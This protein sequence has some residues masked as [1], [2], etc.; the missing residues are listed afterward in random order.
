MRIW[1]AGGFCIRDVRRLL[2]ACESREP[3]Q[4]RCP[5]LP[6]TTCRPCRP[7]PPPPSQRPQAPRPTRPPSASR[8]C[9]ALSVVH[10]HDTPSARRAG[11]ASANRARFAALQGGRALSPSRLQRH[12][13][14]CRRAE[15]RMLA[16]QLRAR[17]P[18]ARRWSAGWRAH[19][20]PALRV[21][22]LEW[23]FRQPVSLHLS[24]RASS[25]PWGDS[26]C[27]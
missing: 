8:T 23:R 2:Q 22:Q 7:R 21:C 10:S 20:W 17:R 19:R 16:R 9:G 3:L 5:T 27:C 6:L 13:L 11:F 25:V 18:R 15:P 26:S 12:L 1:D 4:V 24:G 14:F